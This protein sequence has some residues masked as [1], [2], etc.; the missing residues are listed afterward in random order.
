MIKSKASKEK[1]LEQRSTSLFEVDSKP[2]LQEALPL[3]IQHLLAMIVGNITPAI[4][5]AGV[6]GATTGEK[7]LLIQ[8]TMFIAGIATLMQL[9]PKF[10]IGSGL[11]IVMGVSFSFVPTF[12]GLGAKYG[13]EGIIGAQLVGGI[14]AILVGL[15]IKH[16]RKFLPPIVTGT[17][18]LTIGLSLYNVAADYIAGGADSPIFGNP[19]NF[20]IA[21]A[22]LGIVLFCN[23]F[24]TGKMQLSSLLI[25]IVGGYI[26]AAVLGEVDF[27]PVASAKW[28]ALPQFMPFK[29][30][31]HLDAIITCML[32]FVVASMEMVGDLSALASVSRNR[33][34]NDK[35]LQG[36]ITGMGVI[37][38]LGG[39]IGGLPVATFSQN[40][41]LVVMNK[42]T[43]K[44]VIAI[45]GILMLLAGFI[46]KFGALA[47]TIP[48]P[49]LGGATITVFGMITMSGIQI[50][51]RE[52]LS[53]RD[54]TIVGLAVALG[55]GVVY[56]S[57]VGGLDQFPEW[58]KI[59]FGQS[60]VIVSSL[61]VFTL[62]LLA[63]GKKEVE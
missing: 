7:N 50:L 3:G 32:V 42:V 34:V 41:G 21:F 12:I 8:T 60:A 29:P 33:D 17:V 47:T 18:V 4:I 57:S 55:M 20:I 11:P 48:L 54:T 15:T 59:I 13:I 27:S 5:L 26:L 51:T 44:F 25:G 24:L 62:N 30:T 14:V 43:S 37:S 23:L 6:I 1:T 56:I 58:V 61:I 31:F 38:S 2:S 63:P 52:P 39:L 53:T 19:K 40:V 49:V 36:G 35:E 16:I 28:F 9:Y 46:P 22:T 10:G 45:A